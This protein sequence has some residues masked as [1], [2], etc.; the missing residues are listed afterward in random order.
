MNI[1]HMIVVMKAEEAKN[2]LN[3]DTHID[4]YIVALMQ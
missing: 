4:V 1:N 3:I 2:T